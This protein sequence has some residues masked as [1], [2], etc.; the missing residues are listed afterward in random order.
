MI[1]K[2]YAEASNKLLLLQDAN[3]PTLF[4]IQLELNN[5]YQHLMM[6]LL[7]TEILNWVNHFILDDCSN[8]GL[9]DCFL[10]IDFDYSDQHDMQNDY[11]FLETIKPLKGEDNLISEK[12][13]SKKMY[14]KSSNEF[15]LEQAYQ[16][17]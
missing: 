13:L 4:I 7:P 15:I 10:E 3:K 14:N 11:L 1:Y 12:Q 2:D 16:I 6:Q 17:K 5:L 8:N 9:I